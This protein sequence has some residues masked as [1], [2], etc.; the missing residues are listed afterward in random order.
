LAVLAVLFLSVAGCQERIEGP[1]GSAGFDL[2]FASHPE[3]ERDLDT[4]ARTGVIRMITHYNSTSYFIH[5]GGQAGFDY[6]LLWWFARERDLTV[7][8]IIPD[9]GEDPVHLLNT[10][11]GDLICAGLV[12][13]A[14][15]QPYVAWTRPTN[16]VRKV[17]VLPADAKPATGLA[18]L[19]GLTITL[20]LKDP[21]RDD[22][23]ALRER[24]RLQFFVSTARPHQQAEDLVTA[25]SQDRLEAVVVDDILARS[26]MTYLPNLALGPFLGERQPNVWYLRENSPELKAAL[27]LY[28]K[29]HL[30]VA[31][32]GR[33]RRSETYGI[34]YDR[35]FNNESTIKRF[36]E[37][38]DRPDK[39]GIISVYDELIRDRAEAVGL[40]WRMVASLIYQESEFQPYARSKADARGLMQV[41]PRFAGVQ[42]D[43]LF[44]PEPNLT[45]GLRLLTKIHAQYAYM[46]SLNQW[47]FT[48]A[49]YHA[50][51]GHLTDARRLAM[52][53]GR[54]PNSW[55]NGMIKA[56]PRLMERRYHSTTRHGFY[57]GA[58]TVDYVEEILN[59]YRMYTRLVDRYPERLPDAPP[60]G[61][62]GSETGPPAA[63]MMSPQPR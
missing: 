39:S 37:H 40:D 25:V 15:L 13:V 47:R 42:A 35:Y 54:D 27:N 5:K 3:V 49:E 50:G 12:P 59:R 2:P 20:P 43:S 21:F 62:P 11:E 34:I 22:L 36:Q 19:M 29:K 58:K 51:H 48:L 56:L 32:S 52:E 28:L 63:F 30:T 4:I 23:L 1:E 60:P 16:F 38:V 57:G 26:A 14:E 8:V 6:E 9:P 24:E 55:E 44:D 33:T 17:L 61:F 31:S 53:M 10:G 18:G 41:L 7:E 46:D 45:A